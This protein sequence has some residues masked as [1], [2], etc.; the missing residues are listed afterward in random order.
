MTTEKREELRLLSSW[1]KI[2]TEPEVFEIQDALEFYGSIVQESKAIEAFQSLTRTIVTHR[3]QGDQQS[4]DTLKQAI[5]E[6]R[7]FVNTLLVIYA[8]QGE[9]YDPTL[10][11]RLLD[12]TYLK[13]KELARAKE[14]L[15]KIEP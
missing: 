15:N 8:T 14:L 3:N 7:F 6:A 9:L 4:L 1:I 13:S 10:G 12:T 5:L 11:E 2:N